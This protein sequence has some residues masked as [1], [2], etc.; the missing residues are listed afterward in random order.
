MAKHRR[1]IDGFHALRARC[2]LR[3]LSG[4]V[5]QVNRIL[6]SA[7]SIWATREICFEHEHGVIIRRQHHNLGT[8]LL[9]R[10]GASFQHCPFQLPILIYQVLGH[11]CY[12][13]TQVLKV[14][15][16]GPTHH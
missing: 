14:I 6:S 16:A 8:V 11:L 13:L 12:S 3:C 7:S 2:S 4:G 15:L 10:K 9:F 5:T 1:L